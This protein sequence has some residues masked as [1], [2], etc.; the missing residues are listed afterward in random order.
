MARQPHPDP[1]ASRRLRL[2]TPRERDVLELVARG[3]SNTEIAARLVVEE[4]T[5]K[6]HMKRILAKLSLR[7]RT[8]AVILAYETGLIRPGA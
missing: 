1:A 4:S 3:L 8:Q 2:L 6:T 7:D 5:V